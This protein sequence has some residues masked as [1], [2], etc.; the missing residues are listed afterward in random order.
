MVQAERAWIEDTR[1]KRRLMQLLE[2]TA[3]E[4]LGMNKPA[5]RC[6]TK[7]HRQGS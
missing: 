1:P 7:P 4:P 2:S 5:Y 6:Y 3:R